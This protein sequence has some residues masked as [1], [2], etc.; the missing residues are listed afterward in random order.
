MLALVCFNLFGVAGFPCLD[1]NAMLKGFSFFFGH[2]LVLVN[3]VDEAGAVGEGEDVGGQRKT[4]EEGEKEF[5]GL[6]GWGLLL[7]GNFVQG[8]KQKA[9]AIAAAVKVFPSCLINQSGGGAHPLG[10]SSLA[11][12]TSG[13]DF[14]EAFG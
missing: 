1:V 6:V 4:G 8:V 12:L 7:G 9:V 13:V 11:A 2:G 14:D 5:H 3:D 10:V